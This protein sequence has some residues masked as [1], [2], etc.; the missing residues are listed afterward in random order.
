MKI[1]IGMALSLLTIQTLGLTEQTL[2]QRVLKNHQLL[3]SYE[4]DLLIQQQQ[5]KS[6]KKHYYGW[7]LDLRANYGFEKDDTDKD[8]KKSYVKKQKKIKQN[9]GLALSTSF[10]NGTSFSI[11]F[12]KNM[13]I[14]HQIKH[15][16][17]IYYK[18]Q[19]L[20][21]H[22]NVWT[23]KVNVPLLKN[24]DGGNSKKL[25]DLAGIKQKI[26]TL[27][28]LEIKE[29]KV[30]D[31]LIIFIKLAINIKRLQDY[32]DKAAAFKNIIKYTK[33]NENDSKLLIAQIQKTQVNKSK[34]LSNL[35]DSIFKLK[36]FINFDKHDLSKIN[37][38]ANI[39]IA[40]AKYN[41]E[42]FQKYSRYM[43]IIK[44]EISKKQLFFD[45]FKNK[46]LPDLDVNLTYT[47]TQNRG[48]YS[49]YS[50]K[51]TGEYKVSLNFLYPLGGNPI[52][53]YNLLTSKLE[54][55]K[56][57][58]EYKIKLKNKLID[59][60]VLSNKLKTS[61]HTL[62]TYYRNKLKQPQSTI[63]LNNYLAGKGNIRFV[64]DEIYEYHKAKLEYLSE[65]EGYHKNR[66]KYKNLL[67]KLITTYDCYI[68]QHYN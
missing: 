8:T 1:W 3:E 38:D 31:A 43:Q 56:K 19:K 63:E 30:E 48:N 36:N 9:I 23:T 33:H 58:A 68:C 20:S 65:L 47:K 57:L 45:V 51:N 10:K 2:I 67:D 41:Q 55:K 6:R 50:Y 52:N 61:D 13:P 27:K 60:K 21:E 15:K 46:D 44:L 29:D 12:N 7:G 54:K 5:L 62:T 24:S 18:D 4:I 53:D 42:Y 66:I 14:D 37:F 35:E 40:L 64:L 34:I 16:D 25:Y 59:A 32:K 49:N 39:R 26:K 17:Q 22:N 28:L 11:D